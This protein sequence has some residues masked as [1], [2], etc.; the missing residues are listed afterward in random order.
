MRA[1]NGEKQARWQQDPEIVTS[2]ARIGGQRQTNPGPGPSDKGGMPRHGQH[3]E[4]RQR[5]RGR[6][7]GFRQHDLRVIERNRI[8]REEDGREKACPGTEEQR[9][10]PACGEHG[11][12]TQRNL[13]GDHR[14][15]TNPDKRIQPGEKQRIGGRPDRLR[16]EGG[17]E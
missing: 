3:A 5:Q 16:F 4:E 6:E 11:H 10:N 8:K 17:G 12:G 15:G 14:A 7:Q 13:D 2:R 9:G 1:P